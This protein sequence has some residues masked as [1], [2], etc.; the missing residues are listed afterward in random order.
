VHRKSGELM[1]ARRQ[2]RWN[3]RSELLRRTRATSSDVGRGS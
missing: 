2:E 1:A 3:L